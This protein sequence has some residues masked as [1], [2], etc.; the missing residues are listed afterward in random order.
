MLKKRIPA[1]FAAAVLSISTVSSAATWT[2]ASAPPFTANN[3]WSNSFNWAGFS[4]PSSSPATDI[5]FV[6]SNRLTPFQDLGD[7]F[8]IHN[9]VFDYP[10]YHLIGSSIA[11]AFIFSGSDALISNNISLPGN[12][13]FAGEG[14]ATLGGILSGPGG[15]IMNS[16]GQLVLGA[17]N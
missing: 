2:G 8:V 12:M 17:S 3:N 7:N 14:S 13:T 4:I 15:L 1:A 5:N 6:Q 10:G 9:L 11:P 16:Q